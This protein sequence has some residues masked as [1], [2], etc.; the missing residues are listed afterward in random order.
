M[1]KVRNQQL[2][3]ET[4]CLSQLQH[5]HIVRFIG[6]GVGTPEG[7]DERFLVLEYL[8]NGT[9]AKLI[10][11]RRKGKAGFLGKGDDGAGQ[12]PHFVDATKNT[13]PLAKVMRWAE[14]SLF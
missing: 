2:R 13:I 5:P 4:M 6:S 10:E 7:K 9:L 12:V 11:Q 14:V 3:N 1:Y 8:A